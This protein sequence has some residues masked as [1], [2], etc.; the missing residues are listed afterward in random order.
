V[1]DRT[2]DEARAQGPSA[3]RCHPDDLGLDLVERTARR[4]GAEVVLTQREFDVLAY[5]L[6]HKNAT[7][8]RARL[9]RDVS[10]R[11]DLLTKYPSP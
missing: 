10:P 4:G 9:G 5:L 6:R 2:L 8:T 3:T 1:R 11:E 7:A